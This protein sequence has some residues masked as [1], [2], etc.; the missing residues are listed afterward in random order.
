MQIGRTSTSSSNAY[1]V[2]A[3]CI[4]WLRLKITESLITL[5][6]VQLRRIISILP[7][8]ILDWVIVQNSVDTTMINLRSY[9][10]RGSNEII[11]FAKGLTEFSRITGCDKVAQR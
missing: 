3:V 5:A 4:F 6:T 8:Y 9:L 10:Y 11:Q 7:T 1:S 2:H